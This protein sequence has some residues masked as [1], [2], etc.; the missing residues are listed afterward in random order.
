MPA[1]KS[2]RLSSVQR[3]K[4]TREFTGT[5]PRHLTTIRCI[6]RVR[7][8]RLS[9]G[10]DSQER[11]EFV[12]RTLRLSGDKRRL[13]YLAHPWQNSRDNA[14]RVLW[15]SHAELIPGPLIFS[16]AVDLHV[17]V[18]YSPIFLLFTQLAVPV[19]SRCSLL[20]LYFLELFD[21]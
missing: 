4:C 20:I 19:S 14:F 1:G 15:L 7:P 3:W 6:R 16:L 12:A 17:F 10:R 18:A 9:R 13:F 5:K 21:Q 2:R 8:A 11:V